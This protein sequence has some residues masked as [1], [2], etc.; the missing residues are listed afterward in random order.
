MKIAAF[1]VENLFDRP[2]AFNEEPGPA[3]AAIQAI[4][5]LNSLFEEA[6]YTQSRKNRMLELVDGDASRWLHVAQSQFH[7]ILPAVQRGIPSVW[8]NR[9]KEQPIAGAEPL[10]V[11]MDLGQFADAILS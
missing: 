5:E 7:D 1:N 9:R 3:Q 11:F 2:R 6:N 10:A 4:A 8:I